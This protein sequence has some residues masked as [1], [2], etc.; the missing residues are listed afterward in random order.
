MLEGEPAH[1]LGPYPAKCHPTHP[2]DALSWWVLQEPPSGL[3]PHFLN[4]PELDHPWPHTV[5]NTVL[6]EVGSYG[7][8]IGKVVIIHKMIPS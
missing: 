4:N 8:G 1:C 7:E 5:G 2:T 3:Q 6:T